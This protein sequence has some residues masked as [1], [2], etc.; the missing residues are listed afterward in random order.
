MIDIYVVIGAGGIVGRKVE[1]FL[2]RRGKCVVT[3]PTELILGAAK[4]DIQDIAISAIRQKRFLQLKDTRIGLILAHRAR[5]ADIYEAIISE[6]RVTR[7]LVHAFASACMELRVIVL[8]SVT[9]RLVDHKSPESYHYAK[10][11]QKSCVRYSVTQNNVYMNLLELSWF[12]KYS[13]SEMTEE[14]EHDLASV[15]RALGCGHL[16]NVEDITD[17]LI[18]ILEM[19]RPPRGQIIT[20]DGG[21]SLLQR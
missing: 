14:Y 18:E 19:H 4:D 12:Q 11:F 7:D 15:K 3:L 13:E 8:G 6:I 2:E 10:D 9:G 1:A 5:G 21:Y 16:V 20:F 17:F